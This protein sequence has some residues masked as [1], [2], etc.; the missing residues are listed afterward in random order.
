[1]SI[2]ASPRSQLYRKLRSLRTGER[3]ERSLTNR[4]RLGIRLNNRMGEKLWWRF[5]ALIE[6]EKLFFPD[7]TWE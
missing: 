4:R 3:K 6:E 5:L 1:M 7:S 2:R